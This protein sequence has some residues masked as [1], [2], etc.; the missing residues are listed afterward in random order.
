MRRDGFTLIELVLGVV[1]LSVI[2]PAFIMGIGTMVIQSN[3]AEKMTVATDL[4]RYY[5]ELALSKRFDEKI[6]TAA[7][8]PIDPT[9]YWSPI[10]TDGET[11][12]DQFDDV[13]DFHNYSSSITGF[14]GYSVTM[15]VQYFSVTE[16]NGL[17]QATDCTGTCTPPTNAKRV[18]VQITHALIAPVTLDCVTGALY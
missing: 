11:G 3:R 8:I 2:A 14:P 16:P 17:W 1:I 7:E 5:M 15:T 10:G 12:V 18:R 6:P 4:A 9:T 13:D